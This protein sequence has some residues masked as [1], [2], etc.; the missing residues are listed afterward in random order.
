MKY[1]LIGSLFLLMACN[2]NTAI[3]A[4][5]TKA[6]ADLEKANH[7]ITTLEAQ[8]EP[9]GDLVHLVFLNTKPDIDQAALIAAIKKL[10][11]IQEVMELEVGPFEELN[12][13]RAL[14]DYELVIQLSLADK[15]AYDNYQKHPIHIALKENLGPYL[16]GPP[17]TYDFRKQ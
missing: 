17:A 4:A 16:A 11:D 15:T 5:L 13:A 10:G 8:I 7:T 9:E 12:D 14:S 1:Q 2:N 3:Q 6:Q